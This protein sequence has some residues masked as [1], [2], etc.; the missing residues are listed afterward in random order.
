MDK[1]VI[2]APCYNEGSLIVAFLNELED[3]FSKTPHAFTVVIANDCSTDSSLETLRNYKFRSS[4]YQLDVI[5]LKYNVGHQGAI[6]Q[7]IRYASS[8]DAKGYIVMD[9]DGEDDPAAILRLVNE[10]DFDIVF[11]SRGKR[12]E[13]FS[14]RA[15]YFLYKLLFKLIC[16][17]TI[18]FG[19]YTMISKKVLG[20]IYPQNF[21]HYSA[22]LSKQKFRKTFI[23]FDRRKRIDGK[24]KMNM[25]SLVIHGLNSLLE[26]S[27]ELLYFFIRSLVLI[28]IIFIIYGGYVLYSFFI[29]K[30]AIAGWTSN[31]VIGMINSMLI[32]AGIVVLGLLIVSQKNRKKHQNDIYFKI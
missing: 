24:S 16:G 9:S 19:N 23:K 5:S 15:G 21:D 4:Q 26:Y 32:I 28:L 11:V 7:A 20:A 8:L 6:R 14:F 12:K 18:N 13:S 1:Y 2:I 22:F 27:E 10:S 31:V 30:E 29:S 25:N 17:N 3:T